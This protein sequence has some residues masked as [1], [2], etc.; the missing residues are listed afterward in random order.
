[1][2]IRAFPKRY[3][4]LLIISLS[5]CS[6]AMCAAAWWYYQRQ[7]D[8]I[9]AVAADEIRAIAR[10]K[11]DQI[12]NWR[13]ERIGD[14]RVL[15][16]SF[17][18]QNVQR[19]LSGRQPSNADRGSFLTLMNQ[20][21][22]EYQ[23][24][25]ASVVDLD[26]SVHIRLRE[27]VVPN[28][29]F[30]Q[31]MRRT[32][33][34]EAVQANDVILSDLTLSTRYGKPAMALVVPVAREGAV[35]LE[36]DPGTFLYPYLQSWPTPTLTAES[37]MVRRDGPNRALALSPLRYRP[38]SPLRF[39]STISSSITNDEKKLMGGSL[40]H[41][42]DY[43]G[44]PI[45][46]VVQRI[47]DSPWYLVA[48]IDQ[49]E[50][51]APLRHLSWAVA[52]IIALIVLANAAGV[53]LIWRDRQLKSAQEQEEHFRAVANDTPAY[54]WMTDARPES[55]FINKPLAG[56]LGIDDAFRG[57][58]WERVHPEER[59]AVRE[60]YFR[61]LK[62]QR[63]FAAEF[64]L[65]RFDGQYRWVRASGVPRL[66]ADGR[67]LGYAVSLV[68]ITDRRQFRLQL[69]SANER[70]KSELQERT[71]AEKEVRALTARL[72]NA[73]EE[74]R[75]RIARELHDDLSQQIAALSIGISNLKRKLPDQPETQAQ[76][77]RMHQR[78][79]NLAASTR[80][81]SHELH[82]AVLEYA[83]LTAALRDYCSELSEM[84][85]HRVSF[86]TEGNC[87]VL[88]AQAALCVYRV[89]QEALQNSVKHSG[90]DA[91]D[92]S[93]SKAGDAIRLVVSDR[94][95]GIQ[96]GALPGLGLVSIRERTRLVD[97]SVEVESEPG[98]GVTITL[99]VPLSQQATD[100]PRAAAVE[101][102]ARPK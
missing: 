13:R 26:G 60:S 9:D 77:E 7:R 4:W 76:G 31:S 25:D 37:H 5:A 34:Q 68:D 98:Q 53:G 40:D 87:D 1:M 8:H 70:L 102:N 23:Y 6:L 33:C 64:R 86:R 93:L 24:S 81:L 59:D 96:P 55:S 39:R 14:G 21:T 89:A 36:I 101:P 67:R 28:D 69:I 18:M 79:V 90:V 83:G 49:S 58:D 3:T 95:A 65:M 42:K 11:S 73:Q 15:A 46:R 51:E 63:E 78:L 100:S 99:T 91:A 94:G 19:L 84:T 44:E 88:P 32:L 82:P 27:D 62:E 41:G 80:R 71:R 48:K 20:M 74:E 72:I 52:V 85:Q 61:C 17:L 38:D 47:P 35:I 66:S 16:A 22:K 92:L 57:L 12:A 10:F 54:L 75:T 30:R 45:L 2:G 97:G 29:A 56:F 43:R 50:V